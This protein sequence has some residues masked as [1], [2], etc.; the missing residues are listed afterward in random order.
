MKDTD[1]MVQKGVGWLLKEA[2]KKHPKEVTEFLLKWKNKTTRLILN[3]AVEKLPIKL[4]KKV[5]S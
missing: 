1:I 3:Y 4:K 5:L 2:S